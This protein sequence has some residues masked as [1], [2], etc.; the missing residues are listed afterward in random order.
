MT[1]IRIA[2]T[3]ALAAVLMGGLGLVRSQAQDTSLDALKVAPDSTKLLLENPFVRVTEETVQPG[4]GLP[5]H[6]HKRGVTV[7][8]SDYEVE[9]TIYPEGRVVRAQRHKGEVNWSE[10]TLHAT[11]NVGATVQQAVRIELK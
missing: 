9:Q 2:R 7:A 10:P 3:A 5:K 4:Q 11:R 1:I 8:L 6:N